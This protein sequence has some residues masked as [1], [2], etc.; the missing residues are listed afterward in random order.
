MSKAE[1][2]NQAGKPGYLNEC[3]SQVAIPNSIFWVGI[4]FNIYHVFYKIDLVN[5]EFT[6]AGTH[7]R[8][9]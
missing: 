1:G 7:A 5:L 2:W 9:I 4:I 8:Y 6:W 3:L